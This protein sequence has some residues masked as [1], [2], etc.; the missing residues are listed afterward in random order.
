M[1]WLAQK[2]QSLGQ[3]SERIAARALIEA[4]YRIEQTNVRFPV[5]EIDILA[6]EGQ[7]L[8]FVEVRSVSSAQWGGALA[9]VTGRK[10]RRLIRA[11][12]WYLSH[13]LKLPPEIRFD[14]VAVDWSPSGEP[15][16]QLVRGAFEAS[17]R[18]PRGLW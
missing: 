11:A 7:T 14:V 3:R 1:S 12:Q 16:V 5:G 9:T 13:D 2:R 10:Q 18:S 6:W 4:G 8:C 17:H 15:V